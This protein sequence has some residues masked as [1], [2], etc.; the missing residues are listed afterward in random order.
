MP[1][2]DTVAQIIHEKWHN[3]M[4]EH[5]TA[6]TIMVFMGIEFWHKMMNETP[7]NYELFESQGRRIHGFPIHRVIT[8][9][10]TYV[11]HFEPQI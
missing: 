1:I 3:Y 8:D 4:K 2:Y 10:F 11:I 9:N 5:R 6:P 7:H